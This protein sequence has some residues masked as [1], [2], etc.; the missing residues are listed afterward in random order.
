MAATCSDPQPALRLLFKVGA[1]TN[2]SSGVGCTCLRVAARDGNCEIA[3]ALL[4]AGADL[5]SGTRMFGPK[6]LDMV[7][8]IR[9]GQ[10][11]R[12]SSGESFELFS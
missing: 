9:S 1:N 6:V 11:I 10:G 12:M 5:H 3:K 8:Q 2:A 7:G 4:K